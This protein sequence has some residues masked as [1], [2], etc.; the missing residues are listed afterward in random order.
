M[1]K[2]KIQPKEGKKIFTNH[3]YNK[4]LVLFFKGLLGGSD[5]KESACNARDLSSN[6]FFVCCLFFLRLIECKLSIEGGF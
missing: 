2:L 5:D 4:V 1:K 6:L 3:V